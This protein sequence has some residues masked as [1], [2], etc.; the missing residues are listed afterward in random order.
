[1]PALLSKHKRE[2]TDMADAQILTA[3]QVQEIQNALM[4]ASMLIE[5]LR[6]KGRIP[7]DRSADLMN[8]LA[9]AGAHLAVNLPRAEVG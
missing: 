3:K 5:R 4:D 9:R 2:G 6:K 1:M 8:D 7:Q